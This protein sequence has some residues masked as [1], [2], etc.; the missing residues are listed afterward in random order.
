MGTAEARA[1]RAGRLREE[2]RQLLADSGLFALLEARC[3][4]PSV[5]GSASYDLMVW[6]DI[7]IHAAVEAERWA[8]VDGVRRRAGRT[9]RTSG[10]L[11]LHKATFLN[12]YV[13]PDP[14]GAGLY[15]G[16]AIRDLA[17]NP[18]QIDIWGWEPVRPRG[19]PGPRFLAAHRPRRL[20]PRPDPPPQDRGARARQLLRSPRHAAGTSTSS[21]SPAPARASK[22]WSSGWRSS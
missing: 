22:R 13:D 15:W 14:L 7:D 11:G 3:G 18:W 12:D 5:T 9:A 17:G 16:L 21:A 2:A 20:R 19:A 10:G 6:R 4:A 8:R 1:E